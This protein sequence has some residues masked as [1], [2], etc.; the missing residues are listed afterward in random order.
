MINR[1]GRKTVQLITPCDR[2]D[3]APGALP[4]RSCLIYIGP[5][6]LFSLCFLSF[7]LIDASCTYSLGIYLQKRASRPLRLTNRHTLNYTTIFR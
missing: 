1:R 4:K 2:A 3:N 6:L 7:S 5:I